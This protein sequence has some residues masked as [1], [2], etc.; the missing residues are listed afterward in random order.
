MGPEQFADF[1]SRQGYRIFNTGNSYWYE[2][3]PFC[4]QSIPYHYCIEPSSKELN[5]LFFNKLSLVIRFFSKNPDHAAP[6]YLWIYDQGHYD[7]ACLGSKSRNQTRR[8]LER[9][10]ISELDF[11]RLQNEGWRLI[12][13]TAARQGRN[14]EFTRPQEWSRYCAAAKR[15]ADFEAWGVLVEERLVSFLVGAKIDNYYNILLHASDPAYLKDYPNNA[16]IYTVTKLKIADSSIATVSY[17][18]DSVEDT[19]GLRKF[20][21]GM[22]F[23]RHSLNQQIIINPWFRWLK[24]KRIVSSI[25]SLLKIYPRNNFLRKGYSVLKEMISEGDF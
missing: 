19:P 4:W 6:G 13:A 1:F 25:K 14:P 17:G 20:K 8:G 9:N 2:I 16:L 7:L 21:Q 3:H 10:R 5:K 15:G 12:Q 11:H 24:N 18:L 22:G 23:Y